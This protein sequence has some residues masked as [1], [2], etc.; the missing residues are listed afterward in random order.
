MFLLF[1]SVTSTNFVSAYEKENHYWLKMAIALNCG[2]SLDESRLISVGDFSIDEDPDTQ[3]VRS[4]TGTDNPKWKWH[5]LPTKNP[6]VDKN[7]ASSGNQQIKQRQHEL[8]DRALNDKDASMRLFK[9]GQYLHYQEDK[10][11]HWGYTTGAGHAIP[12]I[13]PG[14]TSPDETHA[15]PEFYRYMVFDSMVNLGKLAK[16]LGKDT[17]CVSDLVPLDT[18]HSAPEYGKDFPWF[19][20]QEIKR[21]NSERFQKTVDKHLADWKKTSLINEVIKVSDEKG[22][23]GVTD[24]FVTYIAK[25]VGLSKSEIL[26]KYD[27]QNIDIDENGN[28]KTLPE[29]LIKSIIVKKDSL[30]SKSV[31]SSKSIKSETAK[32]IKSETSKTSK[33]TDQKTKPNTSL[34]GDQLKSLYVTSKWYELAASWFVNIKIFESEYYSQQA[35][36]IWDQ[37]SK[38]RLKSDLEQAQNL[39]K[40]AN[41]AK[42]QAIMA[43]K[44]LN[45]FKQNSKTSEDNA[46]KAK[47]SPSILKQAAQEPISKLKQNQKIDSEAKLSGAYQ[48]AKNAVLFGDKIKNDVFG[49]IYDSDTSRSLDALKLGLVM[50]TSTPQHLT[51]QQ[52]NSQALSTESSSINL[53]SSMSSI[54]GNHVVGKDSCPTPLGA[55]TLS[56][57]QGGSWSVK[58]KPDWLNVSI[59]ENIATFEFNCNINPVTQ[60]LSGDLVL[61]FSHDGT[62]D[63]LTI[64]V[65]MN[66]L[67]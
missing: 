44:I 31:N 8:Y 2:F 46:I 29:N 27:Y 39:E 58:S 49:T 45:Q 11:S 21:T 38:S 24:S 14:M 50:E 13:V 9:F 26:E 33:Y 30:K 17:E 16:S 51:K 6:D 40:L 64:P 62:T 15:S 43:P 5:A 65:S 57:N 22:D 47:V 55:T 63:T 61:V 1:S 12:N 4:G 18:Y 54:S 41:D 32:I 66:V 7:D 56:P 23:E 60:Q 28:T 48:N 35:D 19:S 25:K 20:P 59:H 52:S 36:S 34:S 37:Y 3:P 53:S 42:A 10:W 67:K